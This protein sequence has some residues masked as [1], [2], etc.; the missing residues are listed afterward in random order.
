[1]EAVLAGDGCHPDEALALSEYLK[2]SFSAGET[3][4]KITTPILNENDPPEE[5]YRL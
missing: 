3:A 4:R 5:R 2:G 1:M